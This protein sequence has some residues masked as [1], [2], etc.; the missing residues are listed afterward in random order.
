M[1]R[2][3]QVLL[4]CVFT[5]VSSWILGCGTP[6]RLESIS[7]SPIAANG[8]TQFVATGT[9][10]DGTTVSPL[11]VLW[12]DNNPWVSS[13]ISP[14]AITIDATG[15]ASCN[16]AGSKNTIVATAPVDPSLPISKMNPNTPQVH[17]TAVLNCP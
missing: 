3:G 12:S 1:K 7:V 11:T 5:L 10:T 17:G 14:P 13:A 9:Y 15:R 4:C 2:I 16:E 8:Q 6:R